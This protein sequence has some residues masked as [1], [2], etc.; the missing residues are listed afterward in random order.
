MLKNFPF[1]K[2]I[3]VI[4]GIEASHSEVNLEMEIEI[5]LIPTM[6]FFAAAIIGLFTF[7]GS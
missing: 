7:L 1:L 3:D 6:K 2:E 4:Q 5:W